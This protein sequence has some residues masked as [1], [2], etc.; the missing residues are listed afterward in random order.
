M[1][2]SAVWSNKEA[3]KDNNFAC[4]II[5]RGGRRGLL[6]SKKPPKKSPKT[7]RPL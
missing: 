4:K 1:Y 3:T 6:E 7:E 2:C 5:E